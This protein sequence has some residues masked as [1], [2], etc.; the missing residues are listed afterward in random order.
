MGCQKGDN[1]VRRF[2]DAYAGQFVRNSSNLLADET[3]VEHRYGG[4]PVS[5]VTNRRAKKISEECQRRV[6]GGE[7]GNGNG[8]HISPAL[9]RRVSASRVRPRS[10]HREES[11]FPTM[12]NEENLRRPG[13]G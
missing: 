7:Y 8:D 11:M 4:T 9:G 6:G 13:D 5:P 2:C 3:G 12:E 10:K 1:E